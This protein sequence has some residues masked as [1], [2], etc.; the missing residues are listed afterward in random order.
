[1]LYT[2]LD[3][4]D[5][6]V[7]IANVC[8]KYAP[9]VAVDAHSGRFCMDAASLLG[10]EALIGHEVRFEVITDDENKKKKVDEELRRILD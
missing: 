2:N 6:A 3:T 7:Q 1:M 9:D 4:I 5:K 8:S 10:M